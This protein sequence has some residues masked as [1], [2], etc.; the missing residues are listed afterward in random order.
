MSGVTTPAPSANM[1]CSDRRSTHSPASSLICFFHS[2]RIFRSDL[3]RGVPGHE[4]TQW[5]Y[6][7]VLCSPHPNG[8][9]RN[10]APVIP[11]RWHRTAR[12]HSLVIA[13]FQMKRVKKSKDKMNN[14]VISDGSTEWK[15]FLMC[16][17]AL[18]SWCFR[19]F[20]GKWTEMGRK[21]ETSMKK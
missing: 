12:S 2:L 18:F 3:E 9:S 17:K 4:G 13:L 7:S 5:A 21:C 20:P 16:E 1:S 19:R 8:H 6:S 14:V 15:I 11:C 10:H